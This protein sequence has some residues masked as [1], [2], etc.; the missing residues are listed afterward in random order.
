MW[1]VHIE[2]RDKTNH[3]YVHNYDFIHMY[4]NSDFG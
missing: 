2:C 1:N 3:K 4:K